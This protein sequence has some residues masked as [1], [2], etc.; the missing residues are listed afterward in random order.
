[1]A[2]IRDIA[3][4]AGVS[5]AAVSIYLR[6]NDTRRVGGERKRKI[7]EA[8]RELEYRPNTF[9][10]ALSRAKSFTIGVLVPYEGP[11][12]RSS[13]LNEIVSGLQTRL[14]RNGYSLAFPPAS[15]VRSP[16]VLKNQLDHASGF[17]GYVL[18][19]TR[20]CSRGDMEENA[21]MLERVG[22]PFVMANMPELTPSVNQVILREGPKANPIRYLLDL[23]HRRIAL[24]AGREESPDS[25]E[26]I[27][28]AAETCGQ[29][30]V[31]LAAED[32]LFGDYELSIA[33]SAMLTRLARGSDL[34]AVYCLS[35]TMAMGV[36]EALSEANLD[37]PSDVSV[38]GRNDSF[39]ARL[40]TPPLTTVQR[41]L[42]E[43]G[44]QCAEVLLRA[45]ESG[46][47]GMKVYLD[48]SL[49]V[50]GST[51]VPSER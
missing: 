20:F 25:L 50:R 38:I 21:A 48:G 15:G 27:D 42:Y 32:I 40:L 34:T 17:D 18:F 47:S 41:P 35:D 6:D 11:V 23:G 44:S 22:I 16:V 3:A 10:R 12:F 4:R 28:Q 9:A 19:G 46:R 49:L 24:M 36:Y 14:F 1:M 2:R 26:G 33:R 51:A 39:F 30:H 43:A 31:E 37:V 45:M 29:Y 8:I 13:F 5:E 7:D